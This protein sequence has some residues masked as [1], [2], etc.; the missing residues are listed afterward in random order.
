LL[1]ATVDEI[2][3]VLELHRGVARYQRTHDRT[4]PVGVNVFTQ[5][6]NKGRT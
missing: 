3:M 1:N 4:R 2:G 6:W 5:G